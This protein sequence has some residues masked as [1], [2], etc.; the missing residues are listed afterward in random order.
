[1]ASQGKTAEP[2]RPAPR[3]Y[4]VTPPD[5][6]GAADRLAQLLGQALDAADVAAVLLRLPDADE[7]SRTN[8]IKTLAPRV[9]NKG[10]ALL[11]DGHAEL[12]PRASADG[13]HLTGIDAFQAA[14]ATL[15]PDRIAGCGGLG[16]RHDA[17]LAAETGA[18]YVMFG[19]PDDRGHR[20]PFDAV[21]DRVAWWAELFEIPCVGFAASIDEVEPL[22]GAGA[23]FVALGDFVFTDQRGCAEVVADA[24]RRLSVAETVS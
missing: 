13:A 18:D 19:E 24:A 16:S 1:M 23:D 2:R 7:R 12:A 6:A 15:K 14:L 3:L 11:V 17:M 20:P 8:Y 4:I 21:V 9:Q 22:V 10:A 5:P